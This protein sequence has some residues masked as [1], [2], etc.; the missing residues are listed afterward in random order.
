MTEYDHTR[1]MDA[2]PTPESPADWM[3]VPQAAQT[4]GRDLSKVYKWLRRDPAVTGIETVY[5]P[6]EK[7]ETKRV[8]YPSLVAYVAT[9]RPGAPPRSK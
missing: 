5:V 8:F 4:L 6:G 2:T 1:G 9:L 7:G 3:S